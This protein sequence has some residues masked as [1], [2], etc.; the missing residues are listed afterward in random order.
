MAPLTYRIHTYCNKCLNP[1]RSCLKATNHPESRVWKGYNLASWKCTCL[2]AWQRELT[3][4][5]FYMS[6]YVGL[7]Q[8]Q[9]PAQKIC[10]LIS[11]MMLLFAL[12]VSEIWQSLCLPAHS[13]WHF[14]RR[15][16]VIAC[17]RLIVGAPRGNST[18]P[19]HLNIT[20]PGV[21]YQCHLEGDRKCVP[22]QLDSA[23]KETCIFIVV[24]VPVNELKQ[25]LNRCYHNIQR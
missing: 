20:E 7:S 10:E 3:I 25:F 18:N 17:S 14:I 23:G 13:L 4:K 22:Q 16:F 9:V 2:Q 1:S 12:H 19:E 24:L 11:Q 6:I 21:V 15:S 8:Y 5:C